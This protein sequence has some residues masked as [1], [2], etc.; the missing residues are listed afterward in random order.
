MILVAGNENT[1]CKNDAK[2]MA[3]AGRDVEKIVLAN[4][5]KLVFD[6][7]VFV[8]NNKTIIFE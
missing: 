4:A 7:R 8:H 1:L 6:D 2:M 5:L 3:R